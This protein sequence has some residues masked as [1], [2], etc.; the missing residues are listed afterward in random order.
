MAT[1]NSVN[2]SLSGQT[3]T[4]QFVGDTSPT[5]ATPRI[6]EIDDTNGNPAL[7]FAAAG[8]ALNYF[9]ISNNSTGSYPY[10]QSFGSD[11]N[12]DF[13][14]VTKGTGVFRFISDNLTSPMVIYNGTSHQHTTTFSFAN[15][16]ANRTVTFQDADG[17]VQFQQSAPT[18]Q[19]FTTGSGTYTT[20]AGV[21]YLI[22]E[23]VGGGGG[24]AGSGAG[25]GSGTA[26][27]TTT[28]GTASATGGNDGGAGGGQGGGS[29]G[30]LN[31]VG[32]YGGAAGG[33][34][35][36]G[37]MG[38]L[39]RF[40]GNGVGG[41]NAPSNGGP[42]AANSGSGG[43]GG[44]GGAAVQSAYGGGSGGF[45]QWIITTPAAT[46]SYAVGTGGTGGA[47]GTSG[48]GGGAGGSGFII[49]YEYYQQA[50]NEKV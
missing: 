18:V 4:G 6:N 44:G 35:T 33:F 43:G 36:A 23:M 22:V 8:S 50:K 26:G 42:A 29:G 11:S 37:G 15:T 39:S 31:L 46:Y 27:G 1:N 25:A 2:T 30:T 47:A 38:G 17:T 9:L 32:G 40:G 21:K 34:S 48:G 7:F 41:N 14:T 19:T 20:P 45:V 28:F 3:G 12:I 13:A 49:V 5:I 10:F 16:A 24:G